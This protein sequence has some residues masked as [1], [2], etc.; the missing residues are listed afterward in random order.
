MFG[1]LIFS[2]VRQP[3]VYANTQSI[4]NKESNIM[5]KL[6]EEVD[7]IIIKSDTGHLSFEKDKLANIINEN[8]S[9][10]RVYSIFPAWR[11][12]KYTKISLIGS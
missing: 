6:I 1:L 4:N 11:K 2:V 10:L 8:Y 3:I 7:E 9:R 5:D 12:M